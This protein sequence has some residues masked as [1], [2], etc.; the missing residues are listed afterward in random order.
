MRVGETLVV[1]RRNARAVEDRDQQIRMRRVLFV[2][3]VLPTLDTAGAAADDHLRKRIGIVSVAVGHV[4]AEQ[5]DRMVEHRAVA[6]RHVLEA[7]DK[8]RENL[9]VIFLDEPQVRNAFRESAPVRRRVEGFADPQV[10]SR[11]ACW[12]P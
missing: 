2:V 12:L 6:I 10:L 1:L 5:N 4:A 11:P 8:L 7:L 3:Q 9:G